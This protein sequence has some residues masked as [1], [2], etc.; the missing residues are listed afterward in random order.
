MRV[1]VV[2]AVGRA[3][4]HPQHSDPAG[5][6]ESDDQG[7]GQD[8]EDDV[9]PGGVVPGHPLVGELGLGWVGDQAEAREPNEAA[10]GPT[11]IGTPMVGG[12]PP[13]YS[14]TSYTVLE[15]LAGARVTGVA[16]GGL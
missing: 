5:T 1:R 13:F 4:H 16:A 6:D 14:L 10:K 11:L 2:L 7:G 15:Q 12:H 8:Q 9:E 3:A